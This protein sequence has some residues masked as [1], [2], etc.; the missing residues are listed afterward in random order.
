MSEPVYFFALFNMFRTICVDEM[1]ST[2]DFVD[3]YEGHY[4]NQKRDRTGLKRNDEIHR[5][6][7]L[8]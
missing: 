2:F 6:E 3:I 1:A 5:H 8:G 4:Y 7:M